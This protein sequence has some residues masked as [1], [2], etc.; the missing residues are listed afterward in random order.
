MSNP[1]VHAERSAKKWGGKSEDYLPIHRWFDSTKTHVPD[2]RHR[3][4]LH[5]GFGIALAEEVFGNQ[6]TNSDHTR[7]FV[8]DI[9]EQH[10]WEDLGFIPSLAECLS[11]LPVEP[12][13]AG[14][15]KALSAAH[16]RESNGQVVSVD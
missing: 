8:R 9:G 14:A 4:V 6:I 7:V 11:G 16:A 2:N 12:W 15:R 3:C 10:V 5:N 13:M 1:Q